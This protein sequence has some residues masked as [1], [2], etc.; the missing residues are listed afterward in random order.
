M[1]LIYV[2]QHCHVMESDGDTVL[3]QN[4]VGFSMSLHL[5][6]QIHLFPD[7]CVITL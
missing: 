6:T 3:Q 4:T 2:D 7:S 5:V 1:L